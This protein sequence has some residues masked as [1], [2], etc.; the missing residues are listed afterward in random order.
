MQSFKLPSSV[1][2]VQKRVEDNRKVYEN[3]RQKNLKMIHDDLRKVA[4]RELDYSKS[5]FEMIVPVKIKWNDKAWTSIKEQLPI[6]VEFEKEGEEE[7]SDD[8]EES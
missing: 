6:I 1:Q 7:L 2:K 5:L 8:E 4:Q 3:I